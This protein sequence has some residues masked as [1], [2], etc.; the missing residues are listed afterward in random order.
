M[1]R[2]FPEPAPA[3]PS[4]GASVVV[5]ASRCAGFRSASKRDIVRMRFRPN[6]RRRTFYNSRSGR[7][8]YF[9]YSVLLGAALALLSP[10]FLLKGL[11]QNKY[12]HS[13]GG[14]LGAVPE[15]ARQHAPRSSA[16][17]A[18]GAVWVHA[19]SVG[20]GPAGAFSPPP[21]PAPGRSWPPSAS[22]PTPL[23]PSRSISPSP[24]AEH[25]RR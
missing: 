14:R 12:L 19:V 8:M 15:S 17:A 5:T 23:F 18:P 13:L 11:R 2:V 9:L 21:L 1:T 6:G 22:G 10:Y 20:E 25:S 4:S 3:S 16:G 7:R 24:A